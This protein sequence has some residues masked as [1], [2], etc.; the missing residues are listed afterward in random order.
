MAWGQQL[1]N[2]LE[3]GDTSADVGR[4]ALQA[5][6]FTPYILNGVTAGWLDPLTGNVLFVGK[7]ALDPVYAVTFLPPGWVW[8]TRQNQQGRWLA[9]VAPTPAEL[10]TADETKAINNE[11]LALFVA[12][13]IARSQL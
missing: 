11:A 1:L 3:G 12:I 2:K 13:G 9:K 10:V 8:S 5:L 4:E 6:G 7:H